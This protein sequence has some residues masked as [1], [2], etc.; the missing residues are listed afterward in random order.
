AVII[1]AFLAPV[2]SA[3]VS[4]ELFWDGAGQIPNVVEGGN[5]LWSNAT[6][7]AANW[8][9]NDTGQVNIPWIDG[10]VAVF[11]GTAGTVTV[12]DTIVFGGMIFH[13][14][15]YQIVSDGAIDSILQLMGSPTITT[16]PGVTATID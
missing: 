5:G 2:G 4:S 16:D 11:Q 7:E 3:Q 10:S 12:T 1:T 15:G 9:T 14:D 8:C 13:T 6:S